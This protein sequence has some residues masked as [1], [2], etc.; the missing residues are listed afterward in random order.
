[1]NEPI[2]Y[3]SA[4]GFSPNSATFRVA[5]LADTERY[6]EM[7]YWERYFQCKQHDHKRYDFSGRLI[8]SMVGYAQPLLSTT[9]SVYVPLQERRPSVPYRIVRIIVNSFT[10]MTFG[11]GRFPDFNVPSDKDADAFVDELSKVAGL[12][13][14]MIQAR[15]IGGAAGTVGLSW[16]YLNGNP[17]VDVHNGKNL[18]VH[19]WADWVNRVPNHVTEVYKYRKDVW[20]PEKKQQVREEYW[21]RRDWTPQADVVF[22]D[23]KVK[24]SEEP[25]WVV[26]EERTKLHDDGFCHFIW[27]RNL[28][29]TDDSQDGLPDC[30]G[31]WEQSDSLDMAWSVLCR[32]T[33]LNLDP[34][35]KLKMD[36][37]AIDYA[38]VRKGSDQAI[39]TGKDGDASY[40]ELA[41]TSVNAGLSL[42]K[43][44]R[45]QILETTEC[46]IPDPDK[47]AAAGTSAVALKMIYALMLGKTDILREQYGKA[48]HE[49]VRQMLMVAQKYYSPHEEQIV[50]ET[51]GEVKTELVQGIVNLPLKVVET[52]SEDPDSNEITITLEP[53][54]PGSNS[55]IEL[56]WGP[57][58]KPTADDHQKIAT[59]L[60][61]ATGGKAFC[62]TK[63]AIDVFAAVL[64]RDPSKMLEDLK[65][66]E[67]AT[68]QAAMEIATDMDAAMNAGG[69]TEPP[70]L[71][72]PVSQEAAAQQPQPPAM[73]GAP[74]APQQPLQQMPRINITATDVAS[75][76][77]V[78][79][80]RASQ[81]LGPM[82][83]PDGSMDPDG[84][85]TVALFKAKT[86]NILAAVAN[87]EKG[88]VGIKSAN[89]PPP[90]P[91]G[92]N[93]P[94][95]KGPPQK[96]PPN[97]PPD[98]KQFPPDAESK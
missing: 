76:V 91:F 81:G 34:T 48:L 45:T 94:P 97:A 73:P 92:G 39:V 16:C 74:A 15:N 19:E 13:S 67:H 95:Q 58:F 12:P 59:T 53:H 85:M 7:T 10:K 6:K 72:D 31:V 64:S 25:N 46:V 68:R 9:T 80:A 65:H 5:K 22:Q 18:Y 44:L 38:F 8:K 20:D 56:V 40:L 4:Y 1:M 32:G 87:A 86:A 88:Q 83:K 28:P 49:L 23:V 54:N 29:G 33:I 36:P 37:E 47:I 27:I 84:F 90:A 71:E 60:V 26:D 89:E 51:T 75:I 57:Y 98:E 30:E 14:K 79:E 78:N 82:V 11:E 17:L 41:G 43:E 3:Q 42:V 66:D 55:Q 77:L 52:E 93:G 63:T 70:E 2:D 96:G 61:Q 24:G 69:E 62:G 50:D 21:Y 35:L